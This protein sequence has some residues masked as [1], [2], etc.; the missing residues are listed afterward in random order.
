MKSIWPNVKLNALGKR[1][2]CYSMLRFSVIINAYAPDIFPLIYKRG[3]MGVKCGKNAGYIREISKYPPQSH[4]ISGGDIWRV[5][6][7]SKGVIGENHPDF[8]G[9]IVL[10]WMFIS[11]PGTLGE[12][13]PN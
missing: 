7:I 5:L 9:A 11:M 8:S 12:R 10:I 1:T 4:R 3:Q 6:T 2:I 13:K